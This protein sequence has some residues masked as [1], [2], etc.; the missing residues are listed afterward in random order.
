[1]KKITRKLLLAL[2]AFMFL[3]NMAISQE[4]KSFTI[5]K[6]SVEGRV[7]FDYEHGKTST[8]GIGG[9]F[10]NFEMKGSFLNG[11]I[12]NLLAVHDGLERGTD[13]NLRFAVSDIT[14]D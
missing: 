11:Q 6:L 9:K 14:A 12:S 5:D 3:S 10:F 2:C 4:Q 7:D 1:M 13:G 8:S